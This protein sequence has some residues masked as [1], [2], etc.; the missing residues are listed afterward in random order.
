MGVAGAGL[1][2]TIAALFAVI[3]MWFYFHKLEKY[4]S[5]ERKL[6]KPNFKICRKILAI[7]FPSGGEFILMF[8]Y[9]AVIYWAIKG[10]GPVAQAGFG[11]GSRIMQSIFVPALAIAFAL[12]ALIGQNY[13]AQIGVRVKQSFIHAVIM[14]SSLMAVLSLMCILYPEAL[15]GAFTEEKEVIQVAALFLSIVA[16]NFVPAGLV[17]TCSGIFQ[18]IG[19]TWPSLISAAS[20]ISLFALPA[21]WLA[22]KPDFEIIQL[23]YLSVA[24]VFI[25]AAISLWMVKHELKNKL[26]FET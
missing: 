5:F 21:V 19:N 2:S 4:V 3:L 25:Q 13:G 20:R 22:G 15:L 8:I 9:M 10:F 7:G 16:I 14:I 26:V 1:A 18:G 12:P 11:L 6:F 24:T 23:W 17:F